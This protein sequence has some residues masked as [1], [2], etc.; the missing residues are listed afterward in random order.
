MTTIRE[1]IEA[2]AAWLDGE[3]PGWR[4]GID[5]ARLDLDYGNSCPLGQT[6]QGSSTGWINGYR[7]VVYGLHLGEDWAYEHGFLPDDDEEG[8]L[9]QAWRDY[10]AE[11]S[12]TEGTD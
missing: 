5:K 10:L 11:P 9:T 7:A 2:G 3:K 8:M 6:F 4:D 12:P 1:R